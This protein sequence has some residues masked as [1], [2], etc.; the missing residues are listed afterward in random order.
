MQK[1]ESIVLFT[2]NDELGVNLSY[3]YGLYH[4]LYVNNTTTINADL[5]KQSILLNRY[6]II[7]T[8]LKLYLIQ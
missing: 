5:F 1:I 8:V 3:I 7:G 4:I 6:W 2:F